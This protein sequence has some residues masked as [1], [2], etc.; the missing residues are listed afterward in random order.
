MIKIS[1]IGTALLVVLAMAGGV[2]VSAADAAAPGDLLYGVDRGLENIGMSLANNSQQVMDLQAGIAAERLEELDRVMQ[3]GDIDRLDAALNDLQQ[4]VTTV[5]ALSAAQETASGLVSNVL[6]RALASADP[7]VL[8]DNGNLNDNANDNTNDNA[9]T[10]GNENT[11]DNENANTNDAYKHPRTGGRCGESGDPNHPAAEK[12]AGEFGV[13]AGEVMGW[14]CGGYGFGE[15]GLAYSISQQ[16]GTPVLAI[17]QQRASGMG[18]G[19]IMQSYG[20]IGKNKDAGAP[21]PSTAPALNN[22]NGNGNNGN[23]G[24]GNN[25]KN[26]GN[27]GGGNGKGK[28]KK[29]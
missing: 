10:N 25:G 15:I 24:N 22:G 11:N 9:N 1:L 3:R 20:L 4:A 2:L 27:N 16:T 13:G 7:S 23:N 21:A 8:A 17:F 19:T 28:G 5:E 6:D 18:W 26:K 12:L 29:S 14:F